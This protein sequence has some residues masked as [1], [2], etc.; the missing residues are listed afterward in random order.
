MALHVPGAKEPI[1]IHTFRK[2][3]QTEARPEPVL[4]GLDF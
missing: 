3:F 1:L 2:P 4:R